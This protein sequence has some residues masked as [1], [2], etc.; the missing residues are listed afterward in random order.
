MNRRE[1][2]RAGSVL[3]VA[4]GFESRLSAVTAPPDGAVP[5]DPNVLLVLFG[6]GTRN[7]ES[8]AD[9][10]RRY[11]PCLWNR[12]RPEG[13]LFSDVRNDGLIVHT[14]AAASILSGHWEHLDLAWKSP[15]RH[16]TLFERVRRSLAL[17]HEDCWALVYAVI[18]ASPVFSEGTGYGHA[19]SANVF[20]PPTVPRATRER[21]LELT[22]RAG[23]IGDSD[24]HAALL[25]EARQLLRSTA[26]PHYEG[27]LGPGP[28]TF[29]REFFARW[30]QE[31]G[32]TSHDA[33]VAEAAKAVMRRFHPRFVMVGFGEIDCAHYGNFSRYTDAI[34]RT[35]ALTFDLWTAIQADA[36][37]RDRTY[38][39]VTPDHGR[40]L[41]RPGGEGFV[42]HS[43]FYTGEGAD[44]GCRQVWALILGPGI[45]KG[46]TRSE[47]LSQLQIAPTI[48][49]FFG[50]E[51]PELPGEPLIA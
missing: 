16:P 14:S 18:L 37:Y 40:E 21:V 13:T 25:G 22:A 10:E 26:R 2:L 49:R 45:P 12:L 6:G 8:I 38:L 5:G 43:N 1:F 31:D 23:A 27:L 42:H 51:W 34:R 35:D 48:G 11:V 50:L 20:Y 3:A 44:E 4:A 15:A 47:A 32:T 28:E 24:R 41:E 9:P 46:E 36:F 30:R 7:S 19:A 33:F 39:V 29:A 17:P